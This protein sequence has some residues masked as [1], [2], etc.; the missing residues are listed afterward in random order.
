MIKDHIIFFLSRQFF[1]VIADA[2]VV[3]VQVKDF[4]DVFNLFAAHFHGGEVDCVVSDGPVE[5]TIPVLEALGTHEEDGVGHHGAEVVVASV[6]CFSEV[7]GVDI[8]L[9]VVSG[10]AEVVERSVVVD[11]GDYVIGVNG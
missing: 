3:V 2:S 8:A 11:C 10:N 1:D 9:P 4:V 5:L 7:V 6:F